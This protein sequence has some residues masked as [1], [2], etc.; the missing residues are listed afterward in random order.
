MTFTITEP[1][2]ICAFFDAKVAMIKTALNTVNSEIK[3]L[4]TMR[5]PRLCEVIREET[6]ETVDV[7]RLTKEQICEKVMADWWF[8]PDG[9][10]IMLCMV[11]VESDESFNDRVARAQKVYDL[12]LEIYNARI[13]KIAV[14][15]QKRQTLTEQYNQLMRDPEWIEAKQAMRAANR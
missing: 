4:E 5:A 2:D 3:Q 14:L 7:D 13:A 12:Q 8:A 9:S 1:Q 10:T 6:S 11:K 15:A